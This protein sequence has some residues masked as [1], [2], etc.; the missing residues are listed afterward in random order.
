MEKT[1]R[2][3]RRRT[4][5]T[6]TATALWNASYGALLTAIN[7]AENERHRYPFH[8]AEGFQAAI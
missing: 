7:S 4:S 6:L 5:P 1:Q 2:L 8:R 3:D